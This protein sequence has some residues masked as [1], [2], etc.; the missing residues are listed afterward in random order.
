V[1]SDG[2]TITAALSV[3]SNAAAGSNLPVTVTDGAAGNHG[4]AKF[5]GLTIS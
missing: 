3:G 1:S 5:S 2:T 4:S